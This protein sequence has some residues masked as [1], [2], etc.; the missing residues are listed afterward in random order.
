MPPVRAYAPFL[1]ARRARQEFL[2]HLLT[3]GPVESALVIVLQRVEGLVPGL[4][5]VGED[6]NWSHSFLVYV[7]V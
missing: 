3:R 2:E 7:P 6:S 4:R 1:V 5:S